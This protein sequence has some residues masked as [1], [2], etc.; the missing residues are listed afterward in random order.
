MSIESQ[1]FTCKRDGLLIRGAQYLPSNFRE[2]KSYPA[3]IISHGFTGIYTDVDDFCRDFARMGYVA[4]GFSF[5]GGSRFD[6]AADLKSEGETT[7]MTILTEVA[8][9]LAV[10]EYVQNLPYTDNSNLV[11]VGFSQGG[12]VSGLAAAKCGDEIRKLIMV[13]PALCIPDH[14]RRGCLG[15]A[16]Y[17][18]DNVPE[19]IDCGNIVLGK[20][21]HDTV[22]GMDP[23]LEL[24]A[25][26]GPVLILQ[27]LEDQI[28]DYSY[29]IRAQANYE[30]GQCHLQLIRLMGHG[31]DSEQQKSL[32]AS[33]RQF[34]ADREEILTIRVVIT[35]CESVEEGEVNKSDVYFT[36]YCDTGY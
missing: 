16:N 33:M 36:G 35:R 30:K 25:Y 34:L 28:V 8:D 7:D 27:G 15:G 14:A 13:F 29:A 31:Y 18:A 20:I 26:K 2:E 22:V 1:L 23:Y 32:V 4:F 21:F 3:V 11:L 5:C 24:S 10:K 9:L 17:D 19:E 12:F 6:A